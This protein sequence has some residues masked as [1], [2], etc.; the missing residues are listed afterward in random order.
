MKSFLKQGKTNS[1]NHF[2]CVKSVIYSVQ[3]VSH[4]LAHFTPTHSIKDPFA[5]PTAQV[6]QLLRKW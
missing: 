1:I 5:C 2:I 6:S 4:P 3:S